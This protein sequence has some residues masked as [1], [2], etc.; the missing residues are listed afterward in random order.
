MPFQKGV[1]TKGAGRP[2]YGYEKTQLKRM[3]T[4]LNRYLTLIEII[5]QGKA[6]V[7]QIT[8]YERLK[9]PLMKIFDKLHPNKQDIK[10]DFE[11]PL[12]IKKD[13]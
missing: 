4:L 12:L 11:K 3:S 10:V 13:D 1:A 8:A 6:S 5:E 7:N 2:G 9:A